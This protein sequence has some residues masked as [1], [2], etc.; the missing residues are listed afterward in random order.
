MSRA[1]ATYRSIHWALLLA[2]TGCAAEAPADPTWFADVQPILAAN[3]ARCHGAD[4]IDPRIATVR[5]D[6][7]VANDG[8]TLDAH[9]YAQPGDGGV[10]PIVRVAV[11]HDYPAMPPGYS[12]S[13]RQRETLRRW[14]ADGAPKG[15]RD[16]RAPGLARIDPDVDSV[17]ADQTLELTLRS[18]DDD[19]DGLRLELWVHD[20]ADAGSDADVQLVGNLGGGTRTISLD[21]GTLASL[22]DFEL[23][24]IVDDGYWDDPADNRLRRTLISDLHVDHGARGTAP[25]VKLLEPNG[26][27]SIVGDV[28][29]RWSATDPDAGDEQL[30]VDLD[31][32]E[33]HAD[34]T[35][36]VV[37]SI[38]ADLPNPS[39]Q[40]LVWTPSGISF[41]D[42]DGNPIL[43]KVRV[44]AT[45]TGARNVRSDESDY[46]FALV[47]VVTTDYTWADVGSVFSQYCTDC[48]GDPARTLAIDY[49]RLDKCRKADA[50]DPG[51]DD[52]AQ[53]VSGKIYQKLADNLMPPAAQPQPSADQ[54]D[55]ILNWIA[56]G[57]PCEGGP[58]DSLPT[59]TWTAVPQRAGDITMSWAADDAEGLASGRIS[60]ATVTGVC[61]SPAADCNDVLSPTWMAVP[62]AEATA[63][64]GGALDWTGS[65]SWAAPPPPLGSCHCFRGEVTDLASQ[66]TFVIATRPVK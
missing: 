19:G 1:V 22:H 62:V 11:D 54:V 57:A 18:W 59:F 35:E 47:E 55:M 29:I 38:A 61:N 21:T 50:P 14:V 40:T 31:L 8:A 30:T 2:G 56:G 23:Y 48:H 58:V 5:L 42:G 36:E 27:E 49:F 32:V 46:V 43:Y 13:D 3:C 28:T 24:A 25:T 65:L 17:T 20:Q 7:Y 37:A 10:A 34:A 63:T 52:G 39:D 26:G 33:V 45:D 51:G 12:L 16:N 15:T 53:E 44:T 41:V 64:L 6:R 66:T 9:D 4:P 60:Y